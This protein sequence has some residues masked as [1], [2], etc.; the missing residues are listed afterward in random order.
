MPDDELLNLLADPAVARPEQNAPWL[1]ALQAKFHRG[2]VALGMRAIAPLAGAELAIR[3]ALDMPA[4]P[5]GYGF[6]PAFYRGQDTL[7]DITQSIDS[8]DPRH[9][10]AGYVE[11][12]AG[13]AAESL[14]SMAAMVATAGAASPEV[15]AADALLPS[16]G[17]RSLGAHAAGTL[18]RVATGTDVAAG[19]AG[20]DTFS[21][22]L[23]QGSTIPTAIG[24]GLVETAG[25]FLGGGTGVESLVKPGLAPSVRLLPAVAKHALGEG[26]EEFLTQDVQTMARSLTDGTPLPSDGQRLYDDLVAFGAGGLPGG[27]VGGVHHAA[28]ALHI[29]PGLEPITK[30]VRP[31]VSIDT[32]AGTV[33]MPGQEGIPVDETQPWL[34]PL[35]IDPIAEAPGGV[36][37]TPEDL[38]SSERPTR[39]AQAKAALPPIDPS[40]LETGLAPVDPVQELAGTDAGT[41]TMD[42]ARA[43][44]QNV[45]SMGAF[46]DALDEP[47][48]AAAPPVVPPQIEPVTEQTRMQAP[49]TGSEQL[50][51]AGFG[52]LARQAQEV[53]ALRKTLSDEAA[54]AP[55]PIAGSPVVQLSPVEK[56]LEGLT[57]EDRAVADAA[58]REPN[59]AQQ[60]DDASRIRTLEAE[61]Y[62]AKAR[63]KRAE[64][65]AAQEKINAPATPA[66]EAAPAP[67]VLPERAAAPVETAPTVAPKE[68]VSAAPVAEFSLKSSPTARTKIN[69][70]V[71]EPAG[72]NHWIAKLAD[73]KYAVFGADRKAVT[74]ARFDK[75]AIPLVGADPIL[76]RIPRKGE[77]HSGRP[78]R[79]YATLEEAREA[80]V[81]ASASYG[82]AESVLSEARK[83]PAGM[84]EEG[85]LAPKVQLGTGVEA[86]EPAPLA[87]SEA[88]ELTDRAMKAE[89]KPALEAIA[90]GDVA[91]AKK[92]LQPQATKSAKVQQRVKGAK[93][94][95]AKAAE[96]EKPILDLA[97][98]ANESF[99][100]PLLDAKPTA[101]AIQPIIDSAREAIKELPESSVERLWAE[102][103]LG[104]Q[105]VD[106]LL[107]DPVKQLPR[108]IKAAQQGI[109]VLARRGR[110]AAMAKIRPTMRWATAFKDGLAP[111][112]RM[113]VLTKYAKSLGLELVA[114][115][116]GQ[117]TVRVGNRNVAIESFGGNGYAY[118][119]NPN[120]LAHGV[121]MISHEAVHD[122]ISGFDSTQKQAFFDAARDFLTDTPGVE[123]RIGKRWG[124]LLPDRADAAI[125]EAV[126]DAG[127]E[128]ALTNR[129]GFLAGLPV[130]V[131]KPIIATLN[132]VAHAI[133]AMLRTLQ[134]LI[135]VKPTARAQLASM[136]ERLLAARVEAMR[137]QAGESAEATLNEANHAAVNALEATLPTGYEPITEDD[138]E[139]PDGDLHENIAKAL[140]WTRLGDATAKLTIGTWADMA[141]V[142]RRYPA[143][144]AILD[145]QQKADS[146]AH[147][148]QGDAFE[149]LGFLFDMPKTEA[150]AMSKLAYDLRTAEIKAK[151]F[152]DRNFTPAQVTR[153]LQDHGATEK[154]ISQ[155]ADL[156][157]VMAD[158]KK[159]ML[160]TLAKAH[161]LDHALDGAEVKQ[162]IDAELA[163]P[164]EVQDKAQIAM[165]ES[166]SEV[167]RRFDSMSPLYAP[168]MRLPG[169]RVVVARGKDGKV[170]YMSTYNRADEA[171]EVKKAGEHGS[172]ETFNAKE[173]TGGGST[174]PFVSKLSKLMGNAG[175][176]AEEIEALTRELLPELVNNSAE[177]FMLQAKGIPGYVEDLRA[178]LPNYLAK[179][180]RALARLD[181]QA[182]AKPALD[183][184]AGS[185]R[186]TPRL[187][188]FVHDYLTHRYDAG[189][190]FERVLRGLRA[191]TTTQALMSPATG[192]A[193]LINGVTINPGLVAAITGKPIRAQAEAYG[194]MAQAT[195][196]LVPQAIGDVTKLLHDASQGMGFGSV[197]EMLTFAKRHGLTEKM[198]A[199]LAD[200]DLEASL[201]LKRAARETDAIHDPNLAGF[202][203]WQH[204]E[205]ARALTK[206]DAGLMYAQQVT[207][208]A[209]RIPTFLALHKA[210]RS[211]TAADWA[212][213]KQQGYHRAP[214]PYE[215]AV[216]GTR[217][218][219]GQ[220]GA[221]NAPPAF[222]KGVGALAF[223]F[224]SWPKNVSHALVQA[225][226]AA[227]RDGKA[228]NLAAMGA[229]AGLAAIGLLMHGAQ[230]GIPWLSP[231]VKGLDAVLSHFDDTFNSTDQF[232]GDRA[233]NAEDGSAAQFAY[234]TLR[235]GIPEALK[236]QPGA[237]GEAAALT[238]AA[239]RR[240]APR[241]L[242]FDAWS[243]GRIPVEGTVKRIAD[244]T[245]DMGAGLARKD[246]DLFARGFTSLVSP[247]AWRVRQTQL[248][249]T[250]KGLVDKQQAGEPSKTV[251]PQ[252]K[253]RGSDRAAGLLGLE[254]E[255]LATARAAKRG[256]YEAK[257]ED[258]ASL[259]TYLLQVVDAMRDGD[260]AGI[261]TSLK[262]VTDVVQRKITA[263]G[264]ATDNPAAQ[265]RLLVELSWLLQAKNPGDAI[266]DRVKQL[267][268]MREFGV[269]NPKLGGKFGQGMVQDALGE[270]GLGTAEPDEESTPP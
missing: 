51:G 119:S 122:T 161:G 120:S 42:V 144:D 47:F 27:I 117:L 1:P 249:T 18:G 6:V 197:P 56:H 41:G 190:G 38:A 239:A 91:G 90:K 145:A 101:E 20:L 155:V 260:N 50:P 209:A 85:T 75:R 228:G 154:Q 268:L 33:V 128:A 158:W 269:F 170:T 247:W 137:T 40:L 106:A 208:Q 129:N 73:G 46:F 223:Q 149:Q 178:A 180:A 69:G 30:P 126:A 114:P 35:G 227:A 203:A 45:Q 159:Q 217:Q 88:D 53:E 36:P 211:F 265:R 7:A 13:S 98:V 187:H 168:Y 16:L 242:I 202:L 163:K 108:F 12:A 192:I 251:I 215:F 140:A 143:V 222:R 263:L 248:S 200:S 86:Q 150:R 55:T 186:K 214:S 17:A 83:A 2:G 132:K 172:T 226:G 270:G 58:M 166:W 107:A 219:V 152:S 176:D 15:A 102:A 133:K 162:A 44:H 94:E 29:D 191:V 67:A 3:N 236:Q 175:F 148:R 21:S 22:E 233:T 153:W 142:A 224:L 171:A 115:T 216:W 212:R 188:A 34:G 26:A 76:G 72:N 194:R 139:A 4:T 77:E 79:K 104:K 231:V 78:L 167:R 116:K 184:L 189:N 32:Q 179:T 74:K 182:Q 57:P 70:E 61:V 65:L 135:G 125:E 82:E 123:G 234:R 257:D 19:V 43:Q 164:A 105:N 157:A 207:E 255:S 230:D 92:L 262:R 113:D 221:K 24:Q 68:A 64:R 241:G 11:Q 10:V 253:V 103:T 206:L 60:P 110:G 96:A 121:A 136:A 112:Q 196:D 37:L 245:V 195:W 49:F 169:D 183:V 124:S 48:V 9:G 229:L 165:L 130:S 151:E 80:G 174:D 71:V 259:D 210:A 266:R 185:A 201:A 8:Y 147:Q 237:V 134:G 252:E 109:E 264:K 218:I 213:V 97:K 84:G 131:A 240:A 54:N 243:S 141:R 127:A 99:I 225:A 254:P 177:A 160:D 87:V 100:V 52:Q 267:Y 258:K 198:A 14:P 31:V 156:H 25:T 199:R 261:E 28:H 93:V 220:Y 39:L 63:K 204:G 59:F 238:R 111:E 23:Q 250:D 89:N 95:E 146:T 193:N 66:A 232:L 235:G 256:L 81:K 181:F 205:A 5:E 62:A 118:I 173:W 138:I 244:A 246:Q